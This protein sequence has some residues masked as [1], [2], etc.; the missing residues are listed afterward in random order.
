MQPG[1]LYMV[2]VLNSS[3]MKKISILFVFLAA[4]TFVLAQNRETRE[5]G[6][7]TRLAF[8]VPGKLYLKQGSPQKVELEG[9]SDVLKEIETELEGDR[10]VIGK[11]SHWRNWNWKDSEKI[12]AYVTVKDISGISVSGSGDLIGQGQ[13]KTGDIKLSVSGSGSMEIEVAASGNMEADVSGS[14]DINLKGSCNNYDS[15]VSGSGKIVINVAVRDQADFGVSGSGEIRAEGT[16][17]EVKTSI[18]GSG[19]VLAGNLV[20]DKC[21][22]RISGS[23]DCEINVKSDLDAQISGSGSVTYKGDPQHV[24]S[25]SSGSG[26]VRKM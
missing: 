7:F 16:A 11:E 21:E 8:R 5:V 10:L 26:K 17:H 6:T 15:D 2:Y 19:K 4:G 1:A 23:G 13:F 12:V 22:I 9:P 24:N 14:G 25:H 20:T 18:S 3:T